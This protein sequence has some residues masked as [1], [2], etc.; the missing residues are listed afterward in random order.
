[1]TS[2][3]YVEDDPEVREGY[4]RALTRLCDDLYLAKNGEEGFAYFKQYQPDIVVS[5]IKMPVKNGID[6]A[7]E[8]HQLNPEQVIIFTTAHSESAYLLEAIELQVSS[9]LLKPV[10]KN[11]LKKKVK[12]IFYQ[13]DL[14]KEAFFNH[15]IAQQVLNKQSAISFV[16]DMETIYFASQ[17]FLDFFNIND[18]EELFKNYPSLLDIFIDDKNYI[19]AKDKQKFLDKYYQL[20]VLKKVVKIKQ[21]PEAIASIF[22]I[23]IEPIENEP[24]NNVVNMDG[25]CLISLT[26]ITQLEEY[27]IITEHKANYDQLTNIYNRRK[28]EDIFNYE[29]LQTHRAGLDLSIAILD[30]DFFKQ[31]NDTFGHQIGDEVLVTLS[32]VV[33]R[34]IRNSDT[35][36]RWG[37][38][39]F[40]LIMPRTNIEAAYNVCEKLRQI[41]ER[42]LVIKEQVITVSIGLAQLKEKDNLHSLFKRC[43]HAL[44]QAKENGRNQVKIAT[45]E[46]A[47]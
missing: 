36:A 21:N 19:A 30:I 7:Q 8:I 40:V 10:D 31:F 3:L 41:I 12:E 26:D 45:D 14:K 15:N 22:K 13:K 34:N 17:S 23:Q 28:F 38:E 33:L 27:K 1:M 46:E 2:I 16:T 37:G 5:D 32:N 39:E 29:L 47:I 42:S 4:A 35:F 25:M 20:P 44:Y 18:G 9:Y 6:M 24:G 11:I 43:D